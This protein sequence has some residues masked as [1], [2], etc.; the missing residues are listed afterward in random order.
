MCQRG[1][2][3]LSVA[4]ASSACLSNISYWRRVACFPSLGN[5]DLWSQ[6]KNDF[7]Y[8]NGLGTQCKNELRDVAW[9]TLLKCHRTPNSTRYRSCEHI[10]TMDQVQKSSFGL[11]LQ[12]PSACIHLQ[13]VPI[14]IWHIGKRDGVTAWPCGT[15]QSAESS[16]SL[17]VTQSGRS[18]RNRH[19]SLPIVAAILRSN[20]PFGG[21]SRGE[22]L[23]GSNM[24]LYVT[25]KGHRVDL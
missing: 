2:L 15:T 4:T 22:G 20:P 21:K 12:L 17:S 16:L 3:R 9:R 8:N 7:R 1:Q 6:C 25:C 19:L 18:Q 14:G 11:S 24:S 23:R 10:L 5:S 13:V